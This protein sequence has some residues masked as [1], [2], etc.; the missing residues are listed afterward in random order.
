MDVFFFDNDELSELSNQVYVQTIK[1]KLLAFSE[2]SPSLP[3]PWWC[4]LMLKTVT[5]KTYTVQNT[6]ILPTFMVCGNFVETQILQSPLSFGLAR[7][8]METV[9]PQNFHSK[10]L[11]E[12]TVF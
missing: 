11:G 7:N 10:K 4:F 2:L 12:T 3:Q 8:S 6:E 5:V 1:K 9:F